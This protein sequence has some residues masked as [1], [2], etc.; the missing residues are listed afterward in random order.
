MLDSMIRNAR[1]TRAEASDVANA[2]VD[3]TDA[4]MLSGESAIGDFPV[5]SVEMLVN[6][7]EKVEKDVCFVNHPPATTDETHALSEALNAIDKILDLRYIVTFTSTGYTAKI[8]AEER[9]NALVV[10][11]TSKK[12]VYHRLNFIRVIIPIFSIATQTLLK[13]RSRKLKLI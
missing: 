3:G 5:K 4:V 13:I 11:F 12:K 10:A 1:P 7:A 8:T 6:I 2:I 9:Y